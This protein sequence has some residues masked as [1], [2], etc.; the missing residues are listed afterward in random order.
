MRSS[1]VPALLRA[2][3]FVPVVPAAILALSGC[4]RGRISSVARRDLFT[5]GIGPLEDQLNLSGVSGGGRR[6]SLAMRDGFFY[7]SDTA[8]EKIV[9]YTSY[10]ELLFMIYNGETAPP[11]LTLPE[12]TGRAGMLTRWSTAY[13]L[14]EPGAL[15]VDSRKHIYAAGKVEDERRAS[16]AEDGALLDNVVVHFDD[17]GRFVN[18]L[19]QEGIGGKPFPRIMDI[20]ASADDE[21]AVVCLLPSGWNVFWF[22]S[23]GTLLFLVH[24]R[25]DGIP[26]P[27][28]A[29]VD[30]ASMDMVAASPDER[31]LF[32]KVDYYRNILDGSGNAMAVPDSSVIWIMNVET[33]TYN[34]SMAVPF[35][36]YTST[37]EGKKATQK[38][39]YAMLGV[40]RHSRV[41]LYFPVDGGYSL[42]VLTA[43]SR[44]QRLGFIQV[45]N[46]E[47]E[48]NTFNLSAEGILSGL[49][50]TEW[51]ARL[52]WWRTD[53]LL[54]E[55]SL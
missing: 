43:G 25:N 44:E 28:E 14:R 6:T 12:D 50:A 9:H 36:E 21:I 18:F 55:M 31:K 15:T 2:V 8:G 5:L 52:V 1:V 29:K 34:E 49:L 13:P 40:I 19:G 48:Y 3:L 7:V 17:A 27:P 54:G 26:R 16:D 37:E 23:E 33:G 10:G 20:Y 32:F 51:E 4:S 53:R 22:N 30:Y 39:P 46:E 45:R 47:L 41:F 35:F 24:L 42:L 38:L 11:P